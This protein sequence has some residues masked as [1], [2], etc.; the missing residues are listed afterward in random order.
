MKSLG[1][2]PAEEVAKFIVEDPLKQ[3]KTG[4]FTMQ[5]I[6]AQAITA[7]R[8]EGAERMKEVFKKVNRE[9]PDFGG[10]LDLLIDKLNPKE[11]VR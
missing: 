10:T 9:L 8:I 7:A 4:A 2:K 1:M 11:V 5:D 6:I 3:W